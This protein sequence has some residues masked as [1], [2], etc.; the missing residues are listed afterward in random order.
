MES[1]LINSVRRGQGEKPVKYSRKPGTK[2]RFALAS[3]SVK[4][5]NCLPFRPGSLRRLAADSDQVPGLAL[6]LKVLEAH[7]RAVGAPSA[8][9]R[10]SII[11]AGV[12]S[13]AAAGAVWTAIRTADRVAAREGA[14]GAR[15]R[16]A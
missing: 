14:G 12:V 3:L 1:N 7:L 6:A 11:A 16:V 9:E 5:E 10:R 2:S 8:K 15:I 4:S 13:E